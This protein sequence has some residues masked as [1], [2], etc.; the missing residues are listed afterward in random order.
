M[1][2]K[3]KLSDKAVI[4][5]IQKFSVHDG[6]GIR[7]IVF[8]KGCPL[9]CRWCQNP[10][11]LK[12][13]PELM[14]DPKNCIGCGLCLEVCPQ[15]AIST[16]E[17]GMIITKRDRC[18]LCGECV[19]VCSPQAREIVGK[20]V[21]LDEVYKKVMDDE[22]FYKNSGGGITLSGGEVTTHSLFARN[23]LKRIK[24]SNINTVIETSGYCKW[25]DLKS[26]LDYTDLILYDIKH[27][28]PEKHKLYTGVSNHLILEN[29]QK[30]KEMNKNVII[31]FPLMPDVNDD[32]T[33]VKEVAR[34]AKQ[35]GALEIHILPF[36]QLGESKWQC[37]NK[38]YK[39]SSWKVPDESRVD[40]VREWMEE[41]GI[42]VN[43]GGSG[44]YTFDLE[45]KI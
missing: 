30:I 23:L 17:N 8:L 16:D 9:K 40:Q 37:L 20:V 45:G 33:H 19:Q 38:E 12:K 44:D 39:C 42:N 43:V 28:D 41:L 31:R 4:T 2:K 25:E 3:D 29:L 24:E 27:L 10:E 15:E 11:T 1:N 21:T 13:E 32:Q 34:L 5:D 7:T 36:H 22:V 14:F 26:I 6:P 35:I 18:N